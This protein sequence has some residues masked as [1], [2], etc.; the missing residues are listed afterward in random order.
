MPLASPSSAAGC[1]AAVAAALCRAL[2]LSTLVFS[3]PRV[4][5]VLATAEGLSVFV[6]AFSAAVGTEKVR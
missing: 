2:D 3:V 6:M 1:R 4:A 5:K